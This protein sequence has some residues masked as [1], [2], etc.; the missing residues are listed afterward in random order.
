[1]ESKYGQWDREDGAGHY[2]ENFAR[3][4]YDY[5]KSVIM[6]GLYVWTRN[7]CMGSRIPV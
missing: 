5:V 3:E 1:M 2:E 6:N 4:K 7:G